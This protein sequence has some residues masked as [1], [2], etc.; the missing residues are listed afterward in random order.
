MDTL[1]LNA[2]SFKLDID[3][4]T[5]NVVEGALVVVVAVGFVVVVVELLAC[6]V[7]FCA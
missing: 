4:L 1:L 5:S 7:E 2:S 6:V 3:K